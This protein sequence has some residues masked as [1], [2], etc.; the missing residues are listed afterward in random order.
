[1]PNENSK[2]VER[3]LRVLR[4]FDRSATELSASELARRLRTRVGHFAPVDL[5]ESQLATLEEPGP[6]E[7]VVTLDGERPVPEL[8]DQIR[9]ACGV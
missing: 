6:D 9:H 8:V 3:A 7:E 5:L 1:M 4:A 2:T